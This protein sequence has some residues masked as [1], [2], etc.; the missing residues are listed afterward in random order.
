MVSHGP[1]VGDDLSSSRR[2]GCRQKR[3]LDFIDKIPFAGSH[4]Q[5]PQIVTVGHQSAGKSSALEAITGVPFP[6]ASGKCTTFPTE[7]RLRRAKEEEYRIGINP[8]ESRSQED[9]ERFEKFSQTSR[10][11]LDFRDVI[12][13]GRKLISPHREIA[14]DVLVVEKFG[15]KEPGLT[16]VDIPGLV[17]VENREQSDNDLSMIGQIADEYM[18]NPRSII[19]VIIN[20]SSDYSQQNILQRIKN[21]DGQRTRTLGVLAKPDLIKAVNLD[22]GRF[23]S[24]LKNQDDSHRLRLGWHVLLN[25]STEDT[26]WSAEERKAKE[27]EFFSKP[28]WNTLARGTSGTESL[29]HRIS[30]LLYR[31]ISTYVPELLMEIRKEL[32]RSRSKLVSLG[33]GNDTLDEMKA[34][35]SHLFYI[36]KYIIDS[37]VCGS[38]T[39]PEGYDFFRIDRDERGTPL[40][41]L[42]ARL[43]EENKL[44]VERMAYFGAKYKIRDLTAPV[45][46]TSN[47][48]AGLVSELTGVFLKLAGMPPAIASTLAGSLAGTASAAAVRSTDVASEPDERQEFTTDEFIKTKVQPYLERNT[49]TEQP[50][51]SDPHHIYKLFANY[52][53][54]WDKLAEVHKIRQELV[55]QVFIDEVINVVWPEH[56]QEPLRQ[57]WVNTQL[58]GRK[59]EAAKE[60][61]R[62]LRDRRD[63]IRTYDP[64]YLEIVKSLKFNDDGEY[65]A[66]EYFFKMLVFYELTSTTFVNNVIAQVVERRLLRQLG[67]TFMPNIPHEKNK[68]SEETVIAIAAEN[69]DTRKQRIGLKE[70]IAHLRDLLRICESFSAEKDGDDD[71]PYAGADTPPAEAY[72]SRPSSRTSST[73]TYSSRTAASPPSTATSPPNSEPD[74]YNEAPPGNAT[75]ASPMNNNPSSRKG[76]GPDYSH[77]PSQ[78]PTR[79]SSNDDLSSSARG[80]NKS[81]SPKQ[82]RDYY[83]QHQ[84][85]QSQRATSSMYPDSG[86]VH[87]VS[88]SASFSERND[89]GRNEYRSVETKKDS[90]GYGRRSQDS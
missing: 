48:T 73:S 61:D 57:H 53:S 50:G 29:I 35:L 49:G 89:G 5:L 16:V 8:H 26:T 38:Y 56:M 17:S 64:K 69:E 81:Q 11:R 13:K 30:N 59:S 52:S 70:K 65:P 10:G 67:D 63:P 75:H 40:R 68:M 15:P 21:F 1:P 2:L 20:G 9:K 24:L 34:A 3:L 90:R 36:S 79:N 32:E 27:R 14:K 6:R 76:K 33:E 80:H 31:Q 87:G 62:L 39:D 41:N 44:F 28:N 7:V 37:A 43:V 78:Q 51:D 74:L 66:R 25:P 54:N 19:L 22:E 46:A 60:R 71:P 86:G 12:E 42:R 4:I 55:I 18:R 45:D 77:R 85:H 84:Q 72:P 23:I 58:E 88:V 82:A 83:P 47:E